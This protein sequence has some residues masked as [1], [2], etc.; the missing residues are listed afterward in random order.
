M[1]IWLKKIWPFIILAVLA[2][3]IHFAFLSYPAQVVFDE[4]HFGK[5]VGAYFTHQYYFD[6]HPPLG[7]LMIAGW[8]K[9]NGLNPV[10]AFEKIG[11][12]VPAQTLFTLRFLPALAGA[13]FVLAFTWLAYLISRSKQTALIAGFLILCC[14]AILVQ[15]KFIL[16]DGFLL[17]FEFLAFCFFLLWQRQKTY[18]V[19]WWS[20]L[21]LTGLSFGLTISIKWTG[22]ATIGVIGIILLVTK[23]RKIK[24]LAIVIPTLL[25][26]GFAVYAIP[27]YIHFQ[28]LPKSGPGDAF[29]G[30][31]FQQEL[32]YGRDAVY[33][34]LTFW[35]KFFELNKTMYTANASI[36]SEHPFGSRWYQWPFNVKPVYYWQNDS[37]ITS[38]TANIYLTGNPLLWWSAS[39]A[40][41][42]TLWLF[43][44]KNNRRRTEPIFYILILAYFANL[45][46]FMLVKRVAFLYHYLLA[47]SFAVMLL[48]FYFSKIYSKNKRV[49]ISLIAIIILGFIFISPL[50]YG[51]NISRNFFSQE[52]K[53]INLLN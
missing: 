51:W 22:V 11:E 52:L 18:G 4:V 7:K 42:Y 24:E 6:I 31:Q 26:L 8:A 53:I 35:Q 1:L 44:S 15:T 50:S 21:A 9:L 10:F 49:F 23:W 16:V 48:S 2:L 5:F 20:Y 34:P 38:Q 28:L 40:V 3:I 29:M 12:A 14:N 37:G 39:L 13:L 46:P 32:K 47:A 27:F 36:T 30:W 19:K 25:I 41:I 43:L 17:L 45:L 33:Q